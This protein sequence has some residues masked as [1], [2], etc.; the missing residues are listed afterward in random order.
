MIA[1]IAAVESAAPGCCHELPGKG[2]GT[3]VVENC[4]R[5]TGH[6][7]EEREAGKAAAFPCQHQ[8]CGHHPLQGPA[9]L[10]E[11]SHPVALIPSDAAASPPRAVMGNCPQTG[12]VITGLGWD[13]SGSCRKRSRR[14][15]CQHLSQPTVQEWHMARLAHGKGC[16]VTDNSWNHRIPA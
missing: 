16:V 12:V 9:P 7:E 3:G 4:Y 10:A 2:R 15:L 6:G 11:P 8:C 5:D 14:G 1:A 13:R